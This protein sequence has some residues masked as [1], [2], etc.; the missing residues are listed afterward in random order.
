MHLPPPVLTDHAGQVPPAAAADSDGPLRGSWAAVRWE[1]VGADGGRRA[2]LIADHGGA[3]TLSMTADA[4][5]LSCT[6]RDGPARNVSGALSLAGDEWIDFSP[7]TGSPERVSYR[8]AASTLVL[9]CESS[10]WDFT[11]VG[12]EPAAFTAVLVRL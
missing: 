11:G 6:L 10:A 5:V 4:C 9:R 1:Y 7:R 8:R 3:I 12:D 2:D